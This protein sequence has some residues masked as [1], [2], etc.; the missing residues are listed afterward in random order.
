MQKLRVALMKRISPGHGPDRTAAE[1]TMSVRLG[2]GAT[3][4]RCVAVRGSAGGTGSTVPSHAPRTPPAP[5]IGSAASNQKSR[6]ERR[7]RCPRRGL[8]CATV[9]GSVLTSI[10]GDRRNI[11]VRGGSQSGDHARVVVAGR[12]DDVGRGLWCRLRIDFGGVE[13]VG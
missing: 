13:R 1:V 9:L 4:A 8:C 11:A 5:A 3:T 7:R 2:V 12:H 6:R 10:G